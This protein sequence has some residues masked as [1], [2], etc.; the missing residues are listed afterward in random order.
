MLVSKQKFLHHTNNTNIFKRTIYIYSPLY[1]KNSGGI[2]ALYNL[3]N[4]LKQKASNFN[5][6]MFYY[7]TYK[8]IT[9]FK[10]NDSDIVIYSEIVEGNPLNGKH[11][12][13]FILFSLELNNRNNIINTWNKTDYIIQWLK[14]EKSISIYIQIFLPFIDLDYKNLHLNRCENTCCLIKKGEFFYNIFDMINEIN[15]KKFIIIDILN[16]E[17]IINTFNTCKYF[18]TYDPV[19]AYTLYAII[20]GCIPII[21]PLKN[22][23]KDEYIK[24][25]LSCEICSLRNGFAYGDFP[26]EIE[27]AEKTLEIGKKEALQLLSSEVSNYYINKFVILLNEQFIFN[28]NTLL[29][30]K[31]IF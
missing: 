1:D 31:E 13:R 25:F 30:L 21:K 5:I 3:Y 18:Y 16:K 11:V 14:W 20:C 19:T 29:T 10:L 23:N 9:K 15:Q 17:Q 7:D 6:H 8:N 24:T 2:S 28:K 22:Y 27:Y 4:L 12:I 26:E